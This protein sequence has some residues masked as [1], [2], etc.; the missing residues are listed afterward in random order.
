M[1]SS[2]GGHL[3][4]LLALRD[5]WQTCDSVW[6]TFDTPDAQSQLSREVFVPAHSPTTRNLM[7]LLRNA[8]LAVQ[9]TRR[10]RPSV[11][12]STGAGVALPFFVLAWV[13]R[14]PT[15]YLEVVDRVD[16]PT[17]TGRLVRPFATRML[18]QWPEQ[19]RFY[20]GAFVTGPVL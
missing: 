1:V 19:E 4:Q 10:W 15:V 9:V 18:V 2:S 12:M 8:R 3:A 13:L 20:R 14:I 6:V 16:G 17:L 11:V 5:W 7:N